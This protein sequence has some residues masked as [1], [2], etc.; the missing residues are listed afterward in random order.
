[1]KKLSALIALLWYM[2]LLF[3]Q[4]MR[5]GEWRA[6]Q[7]YSQTYSVTQDDDQVWF[8]SGESIFSVHKED[9]SIKTLTRVNGLSES[10][11]NKIAYNLYNKTLLIV[12]KN[13]NIDLY[14]NGVVRNIPDISKKII[15]GD[16][17]LNDISFHEDDAYLSFAFGL[18]KIDMSEETIPYTIFTNV[19]QISVKACTWLQ[20]KL[21]IA[22]DKGI[23]E[24]DETTNIM[25]FTAWKKHNKTNFQNLPITYNSTTAIEF[26]DKLYATVDDTLMIYQNNTWAHI[27]TNTQPFIYLDADLS[28]VK[29]NYTKDRILFGY[30][31]SEFKELLKD[32]TLNTISSSTY[33]SACLGVIQDEY[34]SYWAANRYSGAVKIKDGVFEKFSPNGTRFANV[35]D[36]AITAEN[37]VWVAGCGT[38]YLF[39]VEEN[40]YNGIYVLQKNNI[41]KSINSDNSPLLDTVARIINVVVRPS[42]GHVFLGT[43]L[44]GLIETDG[45]EVIKVH[46]A[47]G[48]SLQGANGD[49]PTTRIT[50]VAVD[51]QNNVWMSNMLANNPLS[52]LKPD[53]S[54]KNFTNPYTTSTV[55][56]TKIAIDR[57]G[58]K[59]LLLFD[60]AIVVFDDNG[61]IDNTSDD[62][63]AQITNQNSN[64]I[65]KNNVVKVNCLET[66]RE[67]DI[68]V[69]TSRGVVIFRC[70]ESVFSAETCK[71]ERPVLSLDNF[72]SNLLDETAVN[73]IAVDGANRKWVGTNAGLYLI[74]ADGEQE[75]LHF[76]KDNSP[77]F[78]NNISALEI[79]STNGELFIGTEKGLISY[80]TEAT[81]ANS[82]YQKEVYA[83]PNP[84][85]PD[86]D[87]LIAIKGLVEDVNVKI[88]D[89]S[90][91]LVYETQALGGQAV[92][93]GKDYNGRK[94]QS[95]VYLIYTSNQTGLQKLATKLVFIK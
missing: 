31:Q 18:V 32:N 34:G 1:M 2:P 42:D 75:I 50:G 45:N 56:F 79:N 6:H 8:A 10:G 78:T 49:A 63:Y 84:V 89:V 9:F 94:A 17:S 68:W 37:E 92:W 23:F 35:N 82:T 60:G 67:G 81:S 36:I 87:G 58:Y 71:G 55:S 59:W 72:N 70:S 26:N 48:T 62:R 69:G 86:Y 29:L 13:N 19:Y 4:N 90:G 57:N 95:G 38:N 5:I 21:F 64:L 83:F 24:G 61:T 76:D 12:Y 54:W 51:K 16:I 88:A 28:S 39:P 47:V 46:N 27:P 30:N 14:K 15:T 93:D 53:G 41:W 66:D 7:P 91:K 65:V 20:N 40:A 80:R 33:L 85:R 77:L 22:T 73:C 43:Y 52:V 25:D 74:S 3:G 11:I 44:D